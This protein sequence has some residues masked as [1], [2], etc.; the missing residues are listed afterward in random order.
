[1]WGGRTLPALSPPNGDTTR[2]TFRSSAWP[3]GSSS[4]A[5]RSTGRPC[6]RRLTGCEP[7]SALGSAG[8]PVLRE[9]PGEIMC[10]IAALLPPRYWGYYSDHP[11]LQELTAVQTEALA[12]P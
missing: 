9:Q 1:M 12:A 2:S 8:A 6:R 10:Q 3:A 4:A 5:A 11:R 7:A